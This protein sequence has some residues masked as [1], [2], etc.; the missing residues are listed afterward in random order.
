MLKKVVLGIIAV[1]AMLAGIVITLIGPWPTYNAGDVTQLSAY[2]KALSDLGN[3]SPHIGTSETVSRLQVGWGKAE[4]LLPAGTPLAGYGNRKG[5]P[6]QGTHD[7]LWVKAV[8]LSD[9]TDT[10]VIVGSDMLIVPE[11][12]TDRIW[13]DARARVN[14]EPYQILLNASHTHSGPGAFAPGFLAKQFAGEYSPEI[15]TVLTEAFVSAITKAV[16]NMEPGSIALGGCVPSPEY[17][18]NRTRNAGV[19]DML[20]FFLLQQEDGDRCY[21]I[22]YSAH[23]TILGGDNMQFSGDYPGFLQRAIESE[24]KGMA[25]YLGGAVGSMGPKPPEGKDAFARAHAMGEALAQK[26]LKSS[27]ALDFQEKVDVTPVGTQIHL[28]PMQLRISKNWRMSPVLFR[29]VGLDSDGWI[30]AIRIGNTMICGFP[31]DFSGE[32]S[33]ELHDWAKKNGIDLWCLSFN[34]DY[35]GYISPDRYYE[36]ADKRKEGYEMYLMSWC[37]PNQEAFFTGLCKYMTGMLFPQ[38]AVVQN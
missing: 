34:G 26:V 23:P 18:R 8:A 5:A 12:V 13:E 38:V 14:L 31:A 7:S 20:N 21:V 17:I 24:T 16:Q 4:L 3:H 32:I 30:G 9:G 15:P 27:E 33:S 10:A 25:V 11:N 22:R 28:P 19:D 35:A 36:S 2:Q 6:S 29:L 37:G 1:G